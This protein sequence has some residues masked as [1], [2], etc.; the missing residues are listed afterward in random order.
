MDPSTISELTMLLSKGGSVAML[1]AVWIAFK[2]FRS[3]ENAVQALLDIRKMMQDAQPVQKD[4]VKSVEHIEALTESIDNR[5]TSH[6][7]K[8]TALVARRGS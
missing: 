7:L 1:I 4:M 5:T 6:D 8:L 2:A 3:A